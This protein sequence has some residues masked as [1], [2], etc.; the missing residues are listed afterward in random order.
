MAK[1]ELARRTRSSRTKIVASR[2]TFPPAHA[3]R[4]SVK[5][6]V[7]YTELHRKLHVAGHKVPHPIHSK[8]RAAS[9]QK[10]KK[11]FAA[12][13]KAL[14][15]NYGMNYKQTLKKVWSTVK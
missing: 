5:D 1:R 10:F 6:S 13:D 3:G 8:A 14:Q 2:S 9:V 7:L 4:K 12:V 11:A 15:H